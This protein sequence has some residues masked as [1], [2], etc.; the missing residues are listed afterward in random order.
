MDDVSSPP[1]SPP[2][3]WRGSGVEA[4]FHLAPDQLTVLPD[5]AISCAAMRRLIA[6]CV[7]PGF[8]RQRLGSGGQRGVRVA[9]RPPRG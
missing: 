4:V 3:I 1:S 5:Y 2:A 9:N 7:I 6:L 8:W